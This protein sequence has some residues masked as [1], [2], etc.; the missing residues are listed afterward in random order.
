MTAL[1]DYVKAWIGKPVVKVANALTAEEGL[2]QNFCVAVE[3]GNPLYW[4]S[5]RNR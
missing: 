1:P 2:W 3:D 5:Q 4:Q